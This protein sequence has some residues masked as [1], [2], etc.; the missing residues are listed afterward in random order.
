[1]KESS[2]L[3]SILAAWGAHPRLRLWRQNTGAATLNGRL[4]RFGTPG[5]ADVQGIIRPTGRFLAVE[6][7][8]ATGAQ[9]EAQAKW[10]HMVEEHGG[11]YVLARSLADVDEALAKEGIHR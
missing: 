6:C 8:S 2:L 5:A 11:L 4:V 1:V 9:R 10:Q 7:K 3:Y